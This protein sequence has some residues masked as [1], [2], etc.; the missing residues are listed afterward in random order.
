MHMSKVLSVADHIAVE[1]RVKLGDPVA[2]FTAPLLTGGLF[3]LHVDAGRWVVL[4]FLG[5]PANPRAN[6]EFA[7]LQREADLF[8][9]DRI[10]VRVV[11]TARPD[12]MA[13]Y[14]AASG[15]S[16]SFIA[17]FDGALSRTFGAFDMPRTIVLDPMLRA[18]ANIP[19]DYAQGHAE[20]VRRI[21]RG[22]PAVDDSAGVPMSAPVLIVPRVFSY[23]L[24][25][26]LVKFYDEQG[27]QDSGFMLDVDGKT[28]TVF[29]YNLKRRNVVAVSAPELRK[30]ISD[31]VVHRLVPEI[32]RYFQFQATRMDR[33][34]IACYDSTLGGH[35]HRHRDNLNA[36]AEHRRF[37]VSINLNHDYEGCD[38]MFPE[39]GRKTYRAPEAGAVVFSS[40]AL[41]QVTPI[42]R[43]RRYA[44]LAFLYGEADAAKR[45]ANN[46][47]LHNGEAHYVE[48]LDRLFSEKDTAT[49]AP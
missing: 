46:A 34:L 1:G 42:T 31:H 26:F 13:R 9:E 22:L 23:D 33:Y 49:K 14:A 8:D 10:V 47:R 11:F 2:W 7:E 27:G 12:D 41:H 30:V 18:V 4:C 24:C 36:G 43:G 6:A 38:L 29:D 45:K 16:L 5:S 17:D 35:F 32:E 37:A 44:F 40:G 28:A 25:D 48:G 15:K 21:L 3:N 39:F 20:I 19:W